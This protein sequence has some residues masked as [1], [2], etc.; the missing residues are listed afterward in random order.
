MTIPYPS[1]NGTLAGQDLMYLFKYANDV[2]SGMF[3]P[4]IVLA[5]FIIVLASS[6]FLQFRYTGRIRW[7][8]SFAAACFAVLGFA[9]IIEQRTGL[10]STTYFLI[11][12]LATIISVVALILSPD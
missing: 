1:V 7:E 4:F 6:L 5:F 11:I 12:V 3:M 2:T 9:V 10:L 8:T